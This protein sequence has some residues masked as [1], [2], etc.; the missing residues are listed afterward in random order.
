MSYEIFLSILLTALGVVPAAMGTI[1]A[2][3]AIWFA[4]LAGV[5][6]KSLVRNFSIAEEDGIP[7]DALVR[8]QA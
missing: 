8:K 2:I 5:P 4:A 3:V 1:I 6:G 7:Y